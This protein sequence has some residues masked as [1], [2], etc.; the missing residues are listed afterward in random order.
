VEL[1]SGDSFGRYTIEGTLGVGGMG[2]VYLARDRRLDRRIA[3]KLLRTDVPVDESTPRA[4]AARMLREARAAAALEHPNVVTV[5]D[6][7]EEEGVPFIAMEY[8]EGRS[9]RAFVGD[10]TVEPTRKLGWLLAIARA[11]AAAH[12]KGLVHRDVKPSNVL[13]RTADDVAK[14]VDF[15][16]ARRTD[17]SSVEGPTLTGPGQLVGTPQYMAP[18]LWRGVAADA[19]SDQ[20]AWG[21]L[22]YALLAGRLP[23]NGSDPA[24]LA[25]AILA[26]PVERLALHVDELD[27]RIDGI[28]LRA[29]SR[30]PEA[31]YAST[32]ALVAE[33][34]ETLG[35]PPEATTLPSGAPAARAQ[36]HDGARTESMA[37]LGTPHVAVRPVPATRARRRALLALGLAVACAVA[38]WL[39]VRRV[40]V[41]APTAVSSQIA[42]SADSDAA[43]R[44]VALTDLPVPD[45]P[46][47]EAVVAYV[48][49]MQ[50]YRDGA[51]GPAIAKFLQALEIDP[52]I[53][54]AHLRVAVL[55]ANTSPVRAREHF[56][57]ASTL[58]AGMTQH[59][60]DLLD[61]LEPSVRRDP[62]DAAETLDRLR[63]MVGRYPNDAEVQYRL[64][65]ALGIV[66][67]G[68]R[69]SVGAFDAA[70]ALDPKF[71]AAYARK[72][73]TI[74]YEGAFD[75]ALRTVDACLAA[76]PSS[77]QCVR[78]RESIEVLQG[79]CDA[80]EADARW[81]I[82]LSLT[83][84][85]PYH[86][87]ANALF[88]Q[89]ASPDAVGEMLAQERAHLLEVDRPV[90][91]QMQTYATAILRGDFDAAERAARAHQQAVA[92]DISRAAHG[93]PARELLELCAEEGRD[94]DEA[95]VAADFLRRAAGWMPEPR[96]EDFAL[97]GD[98]TPEMLEALLRTRRLDA[99]QY[100]AKRD[101]W[102]GPWR[103]KLGDLQA[104]AWLYAWAAR[105]ESPEE[106]RA[107]V[108][109]LADFGGAAPTFIVDSHAF[110]DVGRVFFLAGRGDATA[111]LRTG[112]S[113]C[114]ALDF[115]MAH[116]RAQLWYARALAATGDRDGA[117]RAYAVIL[118]RWGHAT[119]RS[120]TAEAARDGLRAA[121]C[122]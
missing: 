108:A 44:T 54:A 7:G 55:T 114:D 63:A 71:G 120:L 68:M 11:L 101:A 41:Q 102:L 1:S 97:A 105:A 66:P 39:F 9:L 36:G 95:A 35:A 28:V 76:V 89:G 25:A 72:A 99:A 2:R 42:P 60:R 98:A 29:L 50:A 119:R 107:A 61:A 34:Q 13:V 84:F 67:G 51:F 6:V 93:A 100:A 24:S 92:S 65:N 118:A 56:E 43:R 22:A 121:K 47:R 37:P 106:A 12:R 14:V 19:R 23:W 83:D 96:A 15:G 30:A 104:Y 33:L 78:V 79:R 82:A 77:S 62:A 74:A 18:E 31:R 117:C 116:T 64:A 57:Q 80:V 115:P 110:A 75:E 21:A 10:D 87:V 111:W 17:P 112:A 46:D 45:S 94:D 48:A 38:A 3:L 85:R 91:E 88:A 109:A 32:D 4:G 73:E 113:A 86:S 52:G 27:P 58:R 103:D 5:Y 40:A 69:S 90:A 59:D 81:R 16:V 8:V 53:A 49:G 20:F 122:P 70:I 26:Q